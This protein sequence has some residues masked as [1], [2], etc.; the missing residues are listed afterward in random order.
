[1]FLLVLHEKQAAVVFQKPWLF[2]A[3]GVC[4]VGGAAF[5]G[6]LSPYLCAA[7]A[8]PLIE[9]ALLRLPWAKPVL[10]PAAI[11][12]FLSH[13]ALLALLQG[14]LAGVQKLAANLAYVFTVVV[15]AGVGAV[16]IPSTRAS[17]GR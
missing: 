14:D 8:L 12:V 10:L 6:G 16:L 5:F 4:V 3:V 11:A 2:I 13:A 7:F 17:L 15:G 9:H 1:M